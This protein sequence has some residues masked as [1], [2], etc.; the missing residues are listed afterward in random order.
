MSVIKLIAIDD[1]LSTVLEFLDNI[2]EENECSPKIQMQ[3]DIA[4]EE[5]FVNV[6]HYAYAPDVGEIVIS[7]DVTPKEGGKELCI[8]L[9]D[10]GVPY[11]PL[12]KPDPDISLSVEEREI[13]GLGIYMAKKYLDL[14]EYEYTD[15]QNV[16]RLYKM[17]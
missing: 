15:G 5:L 4:I 10:R 16:L 11:N 2:L 14:M 13:G 17:I 12:E 8:T 6:S 9:V 3:L 1:N 7:A